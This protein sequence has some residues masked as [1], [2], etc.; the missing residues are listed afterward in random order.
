MALLFRGRNDV[1]GALHRLLGRSGDT[2]IPAPKGLRASKWAQQNSAQ[3]F[4][5]RHGGHIREVSRPTSCLDDAPYCRAD[6]PPKALVAPKKPQSMSASF[7]SLLFLH[8]LSLF[9]SIGIIC[10]TFFDLGILSVSVSAE[11]PL[12]LIDLASSGITQ[13]SVSGR[14]HSTSAPSF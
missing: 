3:N 7:R 5:R 2:S 11:Q 10:L 13:Y 9:V 8:G 14:Y 12:A 1:D 4:D 6:G